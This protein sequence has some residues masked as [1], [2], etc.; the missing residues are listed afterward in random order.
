[1]R[2]YSE[3]ISKEKTTYICLLRLN[4][5]NV[6]L[7]REMFFPRHQQQQ[8]PIRNWI[9]VRLFF[10]FRF[11]F[12]ILRFYHKLIYFSVY[13][14]VLLMFEFFTVI[15]QW[16][17]ER[18]KE[19]KRFFVTT[20]VGKMIFYLDLRNENMKTSVSFPKSSSVSMVRI[21]EISQ[22]LRRWRRREKER[23]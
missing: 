22:F 11:F 10:S 8:I 18:A 9:H 5:P 20:N 19:T 14:F 3:S 21:R 1:M 4:S 12:I 17:S 13:F 6:I 23:K 16:R 2:E 7:L 15:I